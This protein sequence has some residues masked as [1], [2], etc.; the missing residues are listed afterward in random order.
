MGKT[1]NAALTDAGMAPKCTG[2]WAAWATIWPWGSNM[3]QEKSR[4][5]LILGEYDVRCKATPISSDTEMNRLLN[6]S[7]LIGST[8]IGY[9]AGFFI[10][11]TWN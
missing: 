3:A 6:T 9:L 11:G 10:I 4:R 5:S 8:A 1:S 2:T 7:R